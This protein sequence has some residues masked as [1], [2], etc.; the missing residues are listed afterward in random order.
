LQAGEGCLARAHEVKGDQARPALAPEVL[1]EE[2][3]PR[4]LVV[5]DEGVERGRSTAGAAV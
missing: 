2:Q 1:P 3:V 4:F 5:D